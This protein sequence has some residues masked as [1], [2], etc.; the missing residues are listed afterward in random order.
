MAIGVHA[1]RKKADLQAQ[2]A[3]AE[4][5]LAALRAVHSDAEAGICKCKKKGEQVRSQGSKKDHDGSWLLHSPS[6]WTPTASLT[7]SPK[8]HSGFP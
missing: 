7:N 2:V 8:R 6:F 3:L 5:A 4:K 1:Y